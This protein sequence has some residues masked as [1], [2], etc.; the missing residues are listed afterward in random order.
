[1]ANGQTLTE[2][3][4]KALD[5]AKSVFVLLPQ[6]PSLDATAAGL[7]LFLS[8]REAK[9][10][11][12]IGSPSQMQVEYSRLVGIDKI[13]D[14]IGNRNLI[15]SFDYKEDSIEKVSYNVEGEKFNL[16]IQPRPGYPPLDQNSVNFS[17]EGIDVELMIIVGSQK[18]ENLGEMYEKNRQAFSNATVINIDRNAANSNYGQVN[19]VDPKAGSISEMIFHLMKNV[20]LPVN[21]DIAN[22]LL[23]GIEA[24]TNNFQA[25]Y[26]SAES[27]QT[28][29][30]LMRS[31]AK[32]TPGGP[33]QP[34]RQRPWTGPQQIPS[35]DPIGS[36]VSAQPQ[37][38]NQASPSQ[39]PTVAPPPP[40]PYTEPRLQVGNPSNM[41]SGQ[42]GQIMQSPN[43]EPV[44]KQP[45]FQPIAD[46]QSKSQSVKLKTN[47]NQDENID[48]Q[49]QTGKKSQTI[50]EGPKKNEEWMKPKIYQ[51]KTQVE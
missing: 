12:T 35:L 33:T 1:M 9:K 6:N 38:R 31:G 29:A 19:I 20:N 43:Q 3:A 8:I 26:T 4:K 17:Y 15:I 23:K 34:T 36:R 44:Q 21:V 49:L 42:S 47:N 18:L 16:V 32:R 13:S 40:L 27:F 5:S 2:E 28:V 24:Q 14:K 41:R 10:N 11:V 22:N 30:E 51:G 45:S 46:H 48:T 39:Q 37:F 7:A 25:P 50:N